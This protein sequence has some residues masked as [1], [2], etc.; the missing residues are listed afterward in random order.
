LIK[1]SLVLPLQERARQDESVLTNMKQYG[2]E[3]RYLDVVV[4]DASLP[5]WAAHFKLD[6]I[7]ADRESTISF[8]YQ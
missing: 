6:A 5:V 2:L 1:S 3:G 8:K 4:A 7:I